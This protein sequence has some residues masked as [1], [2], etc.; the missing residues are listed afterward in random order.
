[1]WKQWVIVNC[2]SIFAGTATRKVT[3]TPAVIFS[4]HRQSRWYIFRKKI[5]IAYIWVIIYMQKFFKIGV[6]KSLHSSQEN[7]CVRVS[8][9]SV[10]SLLRF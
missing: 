2:L 10:S 4:Y 3:N 1:M 5:I 7:T 9:W 6:L 8:F